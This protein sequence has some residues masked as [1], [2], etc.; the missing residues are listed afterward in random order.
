MKNLAETDLAV[1]KS[2]LL[3]INNLLNLDGVADYS[4]HVLD[5]N[6]QNKEQVS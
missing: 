2:D 5:H 4:R 3:W 6:L 1:K